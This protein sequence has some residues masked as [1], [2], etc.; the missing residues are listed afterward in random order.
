MP[1]P[2]VSVPAIVL[3]AVPLGGMADAV[4]RFFSIEKGDGAPS[5]L[6]FDF[7]IVTEL[8]AAAT[9]AFDEDDSTAAA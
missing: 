4:E 8:M 6:P 3:A 1:D 7:S 2:I 9:C 5:G